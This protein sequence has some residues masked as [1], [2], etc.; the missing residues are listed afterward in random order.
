MRRPLR[1]VAVSSKLSPMGSYTH[2]G[3]WSRGLT[4]SERNYSTTE[5]ECPAIV[6]AILTLRPYLEGKRFIIRTDHHSLR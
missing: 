6:W 4:G 2:L 1:S 5:K 3:Y